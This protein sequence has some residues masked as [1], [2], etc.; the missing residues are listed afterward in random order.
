MLFYSDGITEA[1]NTAKELFGAA[2]LQQYVEVN[3][4]LDPAMVVEGIRKAVSTFS[5]SNQLA[6]DLTAVAVRV[7]EMQVPVARDEIEISSDLHQL[8]QVRDF[9]RRFCSA[10]P[11]A[12]LEEA[13]LGALELAVNEA[14]SNIMKHAY[15]GR[16]DQWIH[17]EAEAFPSHVS[18]RLHHFGD[19]F[20]PAMAPAPPMDTRR[21][22][23]YGAYIITRSVDSV[24][25]YRDERGRNCVV[26]M[27][28]RTPKSV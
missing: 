4:A 9:V 15:H 10:L 22:S 17:L 18:V 20:D 3:G 13:S 12:P 16:V 21:E 24:R 27:K 5:G 28:L 11:D 14:A 2:R 6:D 26:L 8:R 19:P 23:G 7:D 1:R 25:Y